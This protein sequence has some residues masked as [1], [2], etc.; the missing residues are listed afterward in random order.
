MSPPDPSV[1]QKL[2]CLDRSSPGFNGQLSDMLYGEDY[3]RCVPNLRDG[4]LV[5]LVDYL[6][7]VCYH[8]TFPYSPLKP[9]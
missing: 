8:G 2:H 4:D 3:Q 6:D 5:W 1:L 9:V 7:K